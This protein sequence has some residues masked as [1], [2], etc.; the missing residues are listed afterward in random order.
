MEWAHSTSWR[1]WTQAKLVLKARMR[2][3]PTPVVLPGMAALPRETSATNVVCYAEFNV[4][5]PS[6]RGYAWKW[7]TT[8]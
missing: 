6:A 7:V 1:L 8:A 3:K 4:K 5:R 2:T